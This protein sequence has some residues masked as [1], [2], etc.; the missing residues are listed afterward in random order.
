MFTAGIIVEY[1]PFHY[2]HLYHLQQTRAITTADL[3]IAVMSGNFV[4]RGEPAIINKW[5]R[6]KMALGAGVDVVVELP[7]LFAVSSAREFAHGAICA[8][9]TLQVSEFVFGAEHA[10]LPGLRRAAELLEEEPPTLQQ[11]LR[12]MLKQGMPFAAAR[13]Q[14]LAAVE[15]QLAELIRLPNNILAISYLQA[16]IRLKAKI[17]PHVIQRQGPGFHSSKLTTRWAS[18]SAIRNALLTKHK[19]NA[20][21]LPET[22]KMVL[23]Q[24]IESG[25]CPVSL[26]SFEQALLVLLR[27]TT[28]SKLERLFDSE[29]GL[30]QRLSR[31]CRQARNLDELLSC[32]STKRYPSTR[33]QRLLVH[34]LL[35]IDQQL[36][37]Q[38]KKLNK[39]PYIRIL[40][41]RRDRTSLYKKWRNQL[42]TRVIERPASQAAFDSSLSEQLWLLDCRATDIYTL[43][44]PGCRQRRGG[45]DYTTPPVIL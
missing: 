15:P 32:L 39:L 38:A 34:L 2:G 6:T 8:L 17:R 16:L 30:A 43:G 31:C 27:T 9:N 19:I 25:I 44:Y 13:A 12:N 26:K 41:I 36:V 40:G 14:A 7:T 37:N 22:S 1:N 20:K 11:K 42:D 24:G 23:Q 33:L 35:G 5:E 4:Q 18:A 10:E 28:S 3:V 45:Q 29:P 21:A